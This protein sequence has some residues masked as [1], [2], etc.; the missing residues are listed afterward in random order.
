VPAVTAVTQVR[1]LFT[2]TERI[3]DVFDPLRGRATGAAIGQGAG[4]VRGASLIKIRGNSTQRVASD[5]PMVCVDGVRVS[6]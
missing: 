4:A 1:P 6:G 2:E 5:D 3:A